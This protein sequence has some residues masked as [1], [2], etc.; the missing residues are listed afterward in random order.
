M[1][2]EV[3]T[4]GTKP[5]SSTFALPGKT[6]AGRSAVLCETAEK[7]CGTFWDTTSRPRR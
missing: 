6:F 3:V 1:S 7:D 5:R 2:V 4:T